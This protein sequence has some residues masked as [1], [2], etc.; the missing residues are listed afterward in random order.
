MNNLGLKLVW[1]PVPDWNQEVKQTYDMT[2]EYLTIHNTANDASAIAEISYMNGNTNWVSYHIAVDDEQAVHA[3]PFNKAAWHCGDGADGTGNR[4]SIGVEI[5]H[6]LT[7]GNPRYPKAEENGAKMAAIVLHQMGWGIDR[8][9]KHQDWSGKYCPHRILDN[10]DWEN[11][12]QKVQQYLNQLKHGTTQEKKKENEVKYMI[13]TAYAIRLLED[14]GNRKAGEIYLVNV[15]ARTFKLQN[16]DTWNTIK[17]V[18]PE[19][20]VLQ[21]TPAVNY[22]HASIKAWGLTEEK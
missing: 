12:K 11:F 6:S 4:K 16:K 7:P 1:M 9:R 8:M 21:A 22:L 14:L 19:I 18:F 10:G 17:D 3:I 20:K 15:G 13:D 2:P 5:C